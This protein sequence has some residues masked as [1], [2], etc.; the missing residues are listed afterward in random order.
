MLDKE[1]FINKIN[2]FLREDESNKKTKYPSIPADS[3]KSMYHVQMV[4]H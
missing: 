3:V 2:S 4:Y 1:W